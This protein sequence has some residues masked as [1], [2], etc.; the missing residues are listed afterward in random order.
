MRLCHVSFVQL[1][2]LPVDIKVVDW[3]SVSIKS[4]CVPTRGFKSF[5]LTLLFEILGRDDRSRGIVCLFARL[6]R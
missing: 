5:A 6:L 1:A 4:Q 3:T 2:E